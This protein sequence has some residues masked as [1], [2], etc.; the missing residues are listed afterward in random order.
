M[1]KEALAEARTLHLNS[2]LNE[3]LRAFLVYSF[4]DVKINLP[5]N[6]LRWLTSPVRVALM[7]KMSR[8]EISR[9]RMHRKRGTDQVGSEKPA[10]K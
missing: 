1:P 8:S 2:T 6:L 7:G 9:R 10:K 5:T 3:I 4:L